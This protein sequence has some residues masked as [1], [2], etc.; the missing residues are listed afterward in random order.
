[1]QSIVPL[2][3]GIPGVSS[4]KGPLSGRI[5][6]G[7]KYHM[8]DE[9]KLPVREKFQ[10][11]GD[12]GF[13]GT[14]LKTRE[15]VDHDEVL[16]AIRETGTLVHGIVNAG[17][18]DVES[19]LRM[20]GHLGAESV[21]FFAAPQKGF[22][23][24]QNF[25]FWQDRVGSVIPLAEELGVKICME[26]V[27]NTFLLKAEQ[28]ARFIDSFETDSVKS[29]FDLGN[30]ITWTG[31]SAEHWAAV[32]GRRIHKLDI[33]DRG[34]PEFGDARLKKPGVTGTNGGEVHWQRVRQILDKNEFSGWAAA[35]VAGGDRTRLA[36]IRNWMQDVLD[37]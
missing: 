5:R 11:L 26:N 23:Y 31:Q 37:L 13:H 27:R 19:P 22:T 15:K 6:L 3:A 10:L 12:L 29:Y 4:A 18:L 30:T 17:D 34:H 35:E 33:K 25:Q 1:M 20:A 2:A 16:D 7:V 24:E 14:E 32:L 36:G 21:L 9:P 8:I 28:M